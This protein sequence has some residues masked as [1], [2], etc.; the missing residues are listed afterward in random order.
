MSWMKDRLQ[1]IMNFIFLGCFLLFLV[2]LSATAELQIQQ[3]PRFY[4]VKVGKTIGFTCSASDQTLGQAVVK[5]YK[6]DQYD[7]KK[8][9]KGDMS[10]FKNP[11]SYMGSGNMKGQLF[12]KNVE[13]KD[14]GV[15]YCKMNSTW[16]HG[17]ELQVFRLNNR[18]AA[19][20]RNSVKDMIIFFQGFLLMMC[21][22]IPLIWYYRLE[23]KEEAV[24]E[25]PEHDHTY[26]GL[27]VEHCGDLYEDLTAFSPNPDAEASWEIE[28]PEQE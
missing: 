5:W 25:E 22:I 13:V 8:V 20:R 17:T 18:K 12:I 19:E 9:E 26:E 16:G 4:G 23:Q 11:R 6:I 14:S 24:Y 15:Y 10:E 27:E 2:N 28:S 1:E 7:K 3:K 21:I